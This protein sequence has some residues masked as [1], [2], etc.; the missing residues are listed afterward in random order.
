[1]QFPSFD[2]NG[3]VALI[4]GGGR[5]LGRWMALGLANAGADVAV[6]SEVFS[7]CE[8]VA[9]EIAGMN[10]NAIALKT[11]VTKISEIEMMVDKVIEKFSRIDI[12]V[13]NAG[14]SARKPAF[15]VKEEDYDLVTAV[16]LKGAFFCAQIAGKVMASQN[17]GKIINVASAAG[18]L[19]RPGYSNS[20]YSLTKAGLIMLTKC[21]AEEWAGYNINVNA[22]APGY[23]EE[24]LGIKSLNDPK[25]KEAILSVT[26]LKR[27]GKFEDLVGVVVFLASEAANFITGQTIFIDGGRTVV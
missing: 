14:T 23:F 3:K 13:N 12:L 24:G 20:V 5:G 19:V 15:E 21:L 2:L 18:K 22:I 8:S 16:N 6:A 11:D 26:P 4:T 10:R 27:Y 7:E 1:M 17:G 9:N 25:A